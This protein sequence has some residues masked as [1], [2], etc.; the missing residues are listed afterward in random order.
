MCLK[1]GTGFTRLPS[2]VDARGATGRVRP[3]DDKAA[4]GRAILKAANRRMLED[5]FATI[6]GGFRA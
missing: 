4:A 6:A 1:D 2:G 3:R 5:L